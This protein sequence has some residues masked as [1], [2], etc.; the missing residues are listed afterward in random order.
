M[1]TISYNQE[2]DQII[3]I[4]I[5][6]KYS[7]EKAEQ[8]QELS[9]SDFNIGSLQAC[10]KQE[11]FLR[12]IKDE[13]ID[14][15]IIEDIK[16]KIR[17]L[18]FGTFQY[19]GIEIYNHPLAKCFPSFTYKGSEQN[20]KTSRN[21]GIGSTKQDVMNAYNAPDIGLMDTDEWEYLLDKTF[22]ASDNDPVTHLGDSMKFIFKG[23]Q[24]ISIQ[25]YV[26]I[27]GS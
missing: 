19:N 21:I 23:D 17:K 24:V 12:A 25:A 7:P 11:E 6:P 15:K 1:I 14:A 18:D 10:M 27:A 8:K 16:T 4:N 3:K 9:L 5:Q 2:T 26:F 20:Y 22:W 13:G